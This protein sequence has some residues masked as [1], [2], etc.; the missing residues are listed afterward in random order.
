MVISP[1]R[2]KYIS[3]VPKSCLVL[4]WWSD[5]PRSHWV[6]KIEDRSR[7]QYMSSN[8]SM[9]GIFQRIP[10]FYSLSNPCNRQAKCKFYTRGPLQLNNYSVDTF[11]CFSFTKGPKCRDNKEPKYQTFLSTKYIRHREIYPGVEGTGKQNLTLVV[12]ESR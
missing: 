8:P 10:E 1:L 5:S 11:L 12:C 4:G 3:E 7:K 6:R 9:R 2:K